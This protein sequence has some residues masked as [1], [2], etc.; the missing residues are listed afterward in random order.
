[1]DQLFLLPSMLMIVYLQ[2]EQLCQGFEDG[3]RQ[4]RQLVVVQEPASSQRNDEKAE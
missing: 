2:I 1:M 3:V 4:A